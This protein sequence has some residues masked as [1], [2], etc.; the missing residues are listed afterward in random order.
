MVTAS[1][2]GLA[3]AHDT[4]S[5][6]YLLAALQVNPK[7]SGYYN[8]HLLHQWLGSLHVSQLGS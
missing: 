1:A 6:S 3:T 2:W 8:S 5:I 7:L 4:S